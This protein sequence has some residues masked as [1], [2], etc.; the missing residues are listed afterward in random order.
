MEV[1]DR[2]TISQIERLST[3]TSYTMPP[4][5][6]NPL[7]VC[8]FRSNSFLFS[9]ILGVQI[10]FPKASNELAPSSGIGNADSEMSIEGW[11]KVPIALLLLRVM[12]QTA[13]WRRWFLWILM[14]L[15]MCWAIIRVFSFGFHCSN[16]GAILDSGNPHEYCWPVRVQAGLAIFQSSECPQSDL[17]CNRRIVPGH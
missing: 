16:P 7:P 15:T 17:I 5:L 9:I 2:T 4:A 11:S 12:G 13:V 1:S 8:T 10:F 14:V 6:S 3:R